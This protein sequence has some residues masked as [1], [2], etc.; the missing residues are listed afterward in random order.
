[1]LI[2]DQTQDEFSQSVVWCND[3]RNYI[4]NTC[5]DCHTP[6][7]ESEPR[8]R[9]QTFHI[10]PAAVGGQTGYRS[11][12]KQLCVVCYRIDFAK[13]HPGL[14]V[15]DLPDRGVDPKFHAAQ[16]TERR[17]V[18][19]NSI[20][21][22]LRSDPDKSRKMD[23]LRAL[24]E[25]PGTEAEGALAR[26]TLSLLQ[27]KTDGAFGIAAADIDLLERVIA[28]GLRFMG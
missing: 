17:R 15:P 1:M 19:L 25:R 4:P 11:V 5:D 13:A 16:R 22:R 18:T 20:V 3:C 2:S 14:E 9:S 7:V 8:Y 26:E 10:H 27:S 21:E 23:G 6:F 24:A 28:V 12:Q